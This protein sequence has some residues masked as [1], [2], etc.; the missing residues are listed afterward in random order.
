MNNGIPEF[1]AFRD[2]VKGV[3]YRLENRLVDFLE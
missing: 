2:S 1:L 3:I